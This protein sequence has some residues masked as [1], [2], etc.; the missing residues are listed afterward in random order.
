MHQTRKGKQYLLG[1]KA[2][3]G[4][5]VDSGLVHPVVGT[6]ANEAD[7]AV[8]DE[9]LHDKEQVV[10]ADAGYTGADKRVMRKNLQWQIA[11]RPS[12]IRAMPEGDQKRAAQKAETAKAHVRAN[13]SSI[14]RKKSAR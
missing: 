12:R 3:I 1:M 2:H 4:V 10:Y 14:R 8:V 13:A 7:I 5:D 9:L 6:A 11:A